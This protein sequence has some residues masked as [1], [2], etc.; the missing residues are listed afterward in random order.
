MLWLGV[1]IWSLS[2]RF[3]WLGR[4]SFTPPAARPGLT[5]PD[6]ALGAARVRQVSL[7]RS[8]SSAA[9]PGMRATLGHT[10]QY[11]G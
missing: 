11:H 9:I 1:R 4:L 6:T 3:L 8:A 2:L 10:K 7:W 5:L